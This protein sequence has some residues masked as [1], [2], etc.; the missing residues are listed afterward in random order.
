MIHKSLQLEE[1]VTGIC[2]VKNQIYQK[3]QWRK[4]FWC[5]TFSS[6]TLNTTVPTTPTLKTSLGHA[7]FCTIAESEIHFF[8]LNYIFISNL[9]HN[10]LP[11]MSGPS[12]SS[13]ANTPLIF[14]QNMQNDVAIFHKFNVFF[15]LK[16]FLTQLG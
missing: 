15:P 10:K 5:F 14:S 2:K 9:S 8:H 1:S 12:F 16:H 4:L 7:P 13:L 11:S 6:K 3:G